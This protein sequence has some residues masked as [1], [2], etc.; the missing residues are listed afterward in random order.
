MNGVHVLTVKCVVSGDQV[1]PSFLSDGSLSKHKQTFLS[2]V[3]VIDV[4][5][6]S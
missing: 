6:G 2:Y 5:C 1:Q 3:F 4:V